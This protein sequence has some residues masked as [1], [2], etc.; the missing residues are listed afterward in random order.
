MPVSTFLVEEE[1]ID[2]GRHEDL[3]KANG[4]IDR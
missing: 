2:V 3:K 1:W 4:I